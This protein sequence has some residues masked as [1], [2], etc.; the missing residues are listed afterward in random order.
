MKSFKPYSDATLMP[1]PRADRIES[2]RQAEEAYRR[3][4]VVRET[5]RRIEETAAKAAAKAAEAERLACIRNRRVEAFVEFNKKRRGR[6]AVVYCEWIDGQGSSVGAV[7]DGL[8][9]ATAVLA[10]IEDTR[11]EAEAECQRL[12]EVRDAE[13]EESYCQ[14]RGQYPNFQVQRYG[15]FR[16]T[17]FF[18]GFLGIWLWRINLPPELVH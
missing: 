8:T 2:A 13:R 5:K 16:I 3:A 7:G 14:P 17:V 6:W 11:A 12:C 1:C 18:A 15:A 9:S 4:E 10:A